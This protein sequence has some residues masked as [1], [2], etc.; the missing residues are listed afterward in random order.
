MNSDE[1]IVV[2]Y[3][4]EMAQF[5]HIEAAYSQIESLRS[6]FNRCN[7]VIFNKTGI[8]NGALTVPD[9]VLA[10]I[11]TGRYILRLITPAQ[12]QNTSIVSLPLNKYQINNKQVQNNCSSLIALL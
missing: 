12:A 1:M 7:A 5:Q 6:K 2:T 10:I 9:L 3:A 11:T 4:S 8:N